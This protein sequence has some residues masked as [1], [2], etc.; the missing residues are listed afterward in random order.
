MN[1]PPICR[2]IIDHA[3]AA[4]LAGVEPRPFYVDL[5]EWVDIRIYTDQDI[6]GDRDTFLSG[7]PI[8]L[9]PPAFWKLGQR[10]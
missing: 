8:H 6:K 4:E 9:I 2:R 7:V 3:F 5:D 10:E 1:M